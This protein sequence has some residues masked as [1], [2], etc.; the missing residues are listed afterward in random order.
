MKEKNF[1]KYLES[2]D[3]SDVL[4]NR[5]EKIYKFYQEVCPDQLKHIFVN[6]LIKEDGSREYENLWFFS[7]RYCMEAKQ[8]ASNDDFDIAPINKRIVYFRVKKKDYDFNKFTEKSRLNLEI[9]MDTGVYGDLKAAKNNCD[10]LRN[11]IL[12]YIVPNLKE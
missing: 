5:I 7:E 2:I 10:Y 9:K 3:V 6:D 1:I 8:F 11:I 12:K 4:R